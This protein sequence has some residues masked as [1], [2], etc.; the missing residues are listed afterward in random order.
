M[1]AS[2][3]FVAASLLLL[4]LAMAA[5]PA[6]LALPDVPEQAWPGAFDAKRA[7]ARLQRIL[8]D[9]RPHPVD[10]PAN[11]QVRN[12]L[13][14]ELRSVGLSPVVTDSI[15]CNGEAKSRAV[16]CA[17]IRN[18][19]A[20]IGP[21]SGRHVLLV[22]HYDS[23]PVGPG[24]ADDGI[25]VAVMIET[26]AL[27]KDR[28]LSRPVTFL[29][30]EGE[31]AGLN[32]ARAFLEHDPIAAKVGSAINFESRGVTGPAIMFETS[33]PNGPALAAFGATAWHPVANS[34]TAD[35]Y[36]LIP[37]DTDV[38]VFKERPWTI[39]N[40]AVIGNETR[41]HSP[42]DRIA[43]LDP[44]SVR[45]M[46][47]QAV[48][49][50]AAMAQASPQGR[51]ERV[52]ADLLGRGL[53]SLPAPLA[54]F[55]LALLILAAS[56]L[57]WTRRQGLA[58][59]CAV[60]AASMVGSAIAGFLLESAVG[61][62]RSG[63]FWRANPGVIAIAIDLSAL[64]AIALVLAGPGRRCGTAALRCGFWLIFLLI[65][66]ALCVLAPGAS[67]F[68]LLPPC[69]A[70]AGM[71]TGR[72]WPGAE[73]IAAI[74]AWLLLFLSWAPLLHLSEV[75]LD[76]GA[77]WIF[78]ALAALILLPAMI[79]LKPALD[80]LPACGR[81]FA[82]VGAALAGWAALLLVPNYSPDRKQAFGIEY[83]RRPRSAQW[84]VVN[85]GA[86]LPSAFSG[87]REGVKVPWSSRKRWTAPAP[88][89]PTA[90][91]WIERVGETA[92]TLG[93]RIRLRLHMAGN[94]SLILRGDRKAGFIAAAAGGSVARFGRG[95]ADDA[96]SLRCN[97]RS[98]EGLT[99]DLLV[100]GRDRVRA[101]LIG[102]LYALPAQAIPLV[103][104]RPADA[105]PQYSPDATLS[106]R[107]MML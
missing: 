34:L 15:N 49:A 14:A 11:D 101:K 47:E 71:A 65:G 83:V 84:M 107:D 72:R 42:G 17:R 20:T 82:L 35:F 37:N 10:S 70:I 63:T 102:L 91:P 32:G 50:A 66:G 5:K 77:G 96:F 33:R 80:R 25:G 53:A 26:A 48:R 36:A 18:V 43:S 13:T 45:H 69:I 16:S 61:L 87:Y 93:R 6:L 105:A 31:E 28:K 78:A 1:K 89:L 2:A 40:F 51:G 41:Y 55:L 100:A 54:F 62:A 27:L 22:S 76:F 56:L 38:S 90:A 103:R 68:F 98:C 12:R 73:R 23:T 99:V 104:A 57:A 94:D 7:I 44:R 74:V 64:A 39:L 59:A 97:G 85:D 29:F 79:E 106:V 30:D 92:T 3:L 46:G 81:A 95:K 8:G 9:Q 88:L 86:R 60:A 21:A 75:L 52:Y 58:R 24:A 4:I 67:I 19:R